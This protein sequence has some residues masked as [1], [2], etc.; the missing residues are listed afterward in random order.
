M[1]TEPLLGMLIQKPAKAAPGGE[2]VPLPV[3]CIT[4][5]PMWQ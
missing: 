4:K 3:P 1:Y 5:Q 2:L